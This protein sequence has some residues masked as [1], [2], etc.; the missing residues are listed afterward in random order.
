[1]KLTYNVLCIDDDI[2][3]LVA[4]KK[5]F[6]ELNSSVGI[7]TVF[8]DVEVKIGAREDPSVFRVRIEKKLKELFD[9]KI[10]E[11][12][13]VD[14]HM[15]GEFNGPDAIKWIRD[16]HSIY[17]P[18]IFYSAGN[19]VADDT[20][21]TQLFEEARKEDI[22]G[23]N[24]MITPRGNLGVRMNEISSEMHIEE[25][26]VNQARG[27]L[28]DQVSEIDSKMIKAIKSLWLK[29]P[30]S[31]QSKVQ[32]ELRERLDQKLKSACSIRKKIR[33]L[34]FEDTIDILDS[35]IKNFDTF[36]RAKILREILRAIPSLKKNGD[37]FTKFCNGDGNLNSLRNDY[38]HK[39]ATEIKGHDGA[40]CKFIRE[41]SRK[42]N[43]G[44]DRAIQFE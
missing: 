25:H 27:L 14:L 13:L 38:A 12:I 41:E 26:K 6:S 34:N 2:S 37:E 4:P 24:L 39:S 31:E 36:T 43:V 35:E 3:T 40:R 8:H 15:T 11:L 1:M 33:N 22:L 7:E 23:K 17:R 29:V 30:V 32:K 28:M 19:P 18:I 20:A 5:S 44:L 9:E 16:G 42:Y 10:F 21:I